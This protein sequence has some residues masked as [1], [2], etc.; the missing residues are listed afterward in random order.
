MVETLTAI[1]DFIYSNQYNREKL[2]ANDKTLIYYNTP[3]NQI[4]TFIKTT[5]RRSL[6]VI[7]FLKKNQSSKITIFILH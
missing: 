4:N 3:F 6:I 5:A 1:V 2:N 7:K